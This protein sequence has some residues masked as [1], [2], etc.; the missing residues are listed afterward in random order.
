ML[1]KRQ[2]LITFPRNSL[3]IFFVC[4][5]VYFPLENRSTNFFPLV[6]GS[7]CVNL[8]S[9]IELNSILP[10]SA[11]DAGLIP[12]LGGYSGGG[13]CKP[14]PVF[15]PGES[16]G[17]RSLVN[18]RP[19]CRKESDTTERLSLPLRTSVFR[20]VILGFNTTAITDSL[21]LM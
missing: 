14:S 20:L 16:H 6:N 21:K 3:T 5:S 11:G 2:I 18:Y 4:V 10:A 1:Q 12:G 9:T 19:W 7:H 17:Q 15:L 8:Q 13:A